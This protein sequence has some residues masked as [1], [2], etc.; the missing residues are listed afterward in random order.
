M[1]QQDETILPPPP[2]WVEA[3]DR[4]EAQLAAGQVVDGS[5]VRQRLRDSIARMEALPEPDARQTR[6]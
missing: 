1:D 5:A 3:L 2:S 6:R 4:S